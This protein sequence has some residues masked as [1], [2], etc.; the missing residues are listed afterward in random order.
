MNRFKPHVFVLPEDDANRQ[1]AIGFIRNLNINANAIQIVPIAG[2]WEKVVDQFMNDYVPR[3]RQFSTRMIVLLMDFDQ[4]TDRLNVVKNHIPDDLKD[5]VFVLGVLSEPE[6]LKK[7]I[8]K[9]FE[10]IGGS[11]NRLS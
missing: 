3:M 7:K 4:H 5:R 8:H 6:D 2:G 1:I 11:C 10:E 9:T